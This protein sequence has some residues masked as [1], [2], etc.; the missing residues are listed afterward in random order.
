MWF[1]VDFGKVNTGLSTVGYR[2]YGVDGADVVA[3]TITG[4]VAIGNG[5]YG[6]QITPQNTTVGIQWDTG[7]G[8]P[9]Y[10][11]ESVAVQELH[12]LQGLSTDQLDVLPRSRTVG[13]ISQTIGGDGIHQTTVDRD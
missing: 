3:R 11:I 1:D 5:A 6:V 10:A 2:E 9:L 12:A 13:N 4:V 8:D 7:G